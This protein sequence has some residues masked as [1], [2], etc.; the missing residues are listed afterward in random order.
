MAATGTGSRIFIDAIT[1]DYSNRI[2]P[3]V[4]RNT[5]PADCRE[6]HHQV[7]LN[8]LDKVN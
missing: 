1:H 2:N 8:Q 3:W 4:Y 5:L 7:D 6:M